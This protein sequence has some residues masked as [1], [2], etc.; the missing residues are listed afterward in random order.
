[1]ENLK[2]TVLINWS[3]EDKCFV[4]SAPDFGNF[5]KA[6]GESYKEALKEIEKAIELDIKVRKQKGYPI[7]KPG[8]AKR[9]KVA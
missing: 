1:M 2:Y 8:N 5:C 9:L 4:A 6:H 7:P 3:D